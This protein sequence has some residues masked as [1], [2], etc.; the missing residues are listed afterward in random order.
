MDSDHSGFNTCTMWDSNYVVT[1]FNRN[2]FCFI[3]KIS[4]QMVS[5]IF[6][7]KKIHMRTLPTM[8]ILFRWM[9]RTIYALLFETLKK[10]ISSFPHITAKIFFFFFFFFFFKYIIICFP[11]IEK[12][13]KSLILTNISHPSPFI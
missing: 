9:Y 7:I 3:H 10:K 8:S 6:P 1:H 5:G 12:C 2:I 13:V 11:V 4:R